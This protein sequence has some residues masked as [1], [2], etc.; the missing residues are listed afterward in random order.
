MT[1]ADSNTVG[2]IAGSQP[3]WGDY[4]PHAFPDWA[5][6]Y[7][8]DALL[9]KHKAMEKQVPFR[10]KPLVSGEPVPTALPPP[11]SSDGQS[12]LKVGLLTSQLSTK[13]ME[14]VG[15][16]S[17]WGFRPDFVLI[18][19]S[20][21][22]SLWKRVRNRLE[23]GR[24]I[25]VPNFSQPPGIPIATNRNGAPAAQ[26]VLQFCEKAGIRAFE[27]D[28]INSP[29]SL[30]LV[31]EH[32]ID[33]LVYAGAGI[34]KKPIIEAAPLGVLNAHMGLLP[35][36]R[37][38]NVAEWAA[39][40]GE[41]VGCSIHLIDSGIDTGDILLARPVNVS[42][43][44]N[45]TELRNLVDREQIQLLGEVLRYVLATGTL[46][47]RHSQTAGEGLQYFRMHPAI[48]GILNERLSRK[49]NSA[50]AAS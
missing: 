26:S 47:K 14:F 3:V 19:R 1:S 32:G 42:S 39:W 6:K 28:S 29:E 23:E 49:H 20:A 43:A 50:G 22:P 17:D 48:L 34:L 45:V 9:E 5:A 41:P 21:V 11:V 13:V 16:W 37:G 12:M 10:S 7:Y 4:I 15:S 46:P 36:Y 44:A 35:P 38:M 8:V 30:K 2:G 27:V 33:L 24:V 31:H 40:N 18:E 25:Q